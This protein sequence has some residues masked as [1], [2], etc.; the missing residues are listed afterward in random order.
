MTIRVSVFLDGEE[1]V[2]NPELPQ[3]RL[4]I[5]EDQDVA[6]RIVLTGSDFDIVPMAFVEDYLLSLSQDIVQTKQETK[7]VFSCPPG[8]HFRES[9]GSAVLRLSIADHEHILGFEVLAKKVHAAQAEDM[10]RFLT[11]KSE[12]IIRVCLARTSRP[13]GSDGLGKADPEM[14]L[15]A[16]E[17]F[18]SYLLEVRMDLRHQIRTR[19]SPVRQPSWKAL[20]NGG[21][22]DPLDVLLNLDALQPATDEGDVRIKGRRFSAL[23]IDVTTLEQSADVE[24]NTALLGGLYSMQRILLSLSQEISATFSGG[25][26]ASHDKEYVSLSELLLRLSAGGMN[27]R[28]DKLL[29]TIGELVRYFEKTLKVPYRGEIKPRLTPHVR[30]SRLYRILFEKLT[31]WYALGSP[32]LEGQMFMIKLRSLS[33]IFEYFTLY[34]IFDYLES[35]EWDLI[36]SKFDPDFEK[37]IPSHLVFRKEGV[38]VTLDY[39]PKVFPLSEDTPN[40]SLVDLK[41]SKASG[42]YW[43]PDFSLKIDVNGSVCF[44]IIDAKYSTPSMIREKHLP[45][46]YDK[47]FTDMAVYDS[48]RKILDH[49]RIYGVLAVFPGQEKFTLPTS[50]RWGRHG[51]LTGNVVRLPVVSGLPLSINSEGIMEKSFDRMIEIA[52]THL[53][54]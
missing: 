39:E 54:S 52:M 8:R 43:W 7:N 27:Q 32:S 2:W 36:F 12:H 9:F 26:L 50:W 46:L 29:T 23:G 31:H 41:H 14:V 25:H 35:R 15:S 47:Y 6:L 3:P 28:C 49:G 18:V 4:V 33:K 51:I 38:T 5:R 40:F 19:L 10:I 45:H 11:K 1:V 42:T 13:V 22:I 20:L 44:Y 21:S 34:R 48:K 53:A 30:A 16:A 24:E 17:N 37:M